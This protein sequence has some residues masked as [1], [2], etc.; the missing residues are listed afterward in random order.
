M[1]DATARTTGAGIGVFG[2][3]AALAGCIPGELPVGVLGTAIAK[4]G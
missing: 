1:T 2:S 3:G 4:L